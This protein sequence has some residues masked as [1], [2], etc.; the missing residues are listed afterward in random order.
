MDKGAYLDFLQQS[1]EQLDGE[2]YRAKN[3]DL[4]GMPALLDLFVW[5]RLFLLM[6]SDVVRSEP[7]LADYEERKRNLTIAL[8]CSMDIPYR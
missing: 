6:E 2:A 3:F 4:P 1:I 7:E 8:K 5:L